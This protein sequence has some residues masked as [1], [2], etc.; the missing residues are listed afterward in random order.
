ME[1]YGKR[2]RLRLEHLD[3]KDRKMGQQL[4]SAR[5]KMT[6]IL[7]KRK[8][9]P[10]EARR[11]VE[12]TLDIAADC[13][14]DLW[15]RDQDLRD[16]SRSQ[17]DVRQ[18]SKQ[19]GHL[20]QAIS[21]LPPWAIGK[22]NKIIVEQDWQNFDTELFTTLIRAVLDTLAKLSPARVANEARLAMSLLGLPKIPELIKW[23]GPRHQKSWNYGKPYRLQRGPRPKRACEI[24]RHRREGQPLPF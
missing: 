16:L 2:V 6:Q 10:D 17:R 1:R 11:A 5:E 18:L 9:R 13:Q 23:S 4:A 21:D 19:L 14:L 20:Q 3:L 15:R 8:I 12:Q 24:G 22:L 7:I